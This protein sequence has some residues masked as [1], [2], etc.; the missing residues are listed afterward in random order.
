[1]T[2]EKGRRMQP[3][4][5]K[6]KTVSEVMASIH[7]QDTKP[8]IAARHWL[9]TH[10]YRYRKNVSGLPG[11]P[12]IVVTASRT[13]IFIHGCF[14]HQHEG[15]KAYSTPH[16]NTEFWQNKFA[17][18]KG[19]DERV[20]IELRAIGWRTMV[21]WECQ[22]KPAVL[23]ATMEAAAKLLDEA[24]EEWEHQH[25]ATKKSSA[26]TNPYD[27]DDEDPRYAYAAEE[28]ALSSYGME[29]E[30]ETEFDETE[31]PMAAEDTV[32]GS[33]AKRANKKTDDNNRDKM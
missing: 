3:R 2:E 23:E 20:R 5:R 33:Y 27:I 12:D 1:M 14:W 13:A 22:L 29:Q 30:E 9:W 11:K 18:N 17:R 21:I 26:I 16:T 7:S 6:P 24:R 10:G 28:G 25:M 4:R 32:F 19:R 15:C 8:E 31:L